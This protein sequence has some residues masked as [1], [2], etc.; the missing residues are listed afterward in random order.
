MRTQACY[1]AEQIAPHKDRLTPEH[2]AIL[3]AMADGKTRKS[4]AEA[5][6]IPVGTQKSRLSRAR[7]ALAAMIA[8]NKGNGR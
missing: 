1:T 4:A 8:D 6:G 5:L 2:F 7:K 3:M